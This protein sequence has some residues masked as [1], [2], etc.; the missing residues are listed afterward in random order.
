MSQ[1]LAFNSVNL[2]W[3]PPAEGSFKVNCDASKMG[4]EDLIGFGCVI[5]DFNGN[6]QHGC[7]GIIHHHSVLQ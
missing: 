4:N 3:H 7:A 1:S 6:W 2:N 5:R